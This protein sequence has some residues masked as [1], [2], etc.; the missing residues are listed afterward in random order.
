MP[1]Q[2]GSNK[3]DSELKPVAAQ[4]GETLYRAAKDAIRS[5]IDNGT[6]KPGEQLPSTKVIGRQMR[7]SLVTAHRALQELVTSGVLER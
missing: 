1:G 2:S 7:I 3:R 4:P 6:F 5:A